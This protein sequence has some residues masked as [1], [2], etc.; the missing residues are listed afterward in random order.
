MTPT[1]AEALF[2]L[3]ATELASHHIQP[4]ASRGKQDSVQTIQSSHRLDVIYAWLTGA[5]PT[6]PNSKVTDAASPDYN[7][8]LGDVMDLGCGQGDLTGALAF[9]VAAHPEHFERTQARPTR[10]VGVD[11]APADYGSPYTLQQAQD[12][13][14]Q[15]SILK[16]HLSFVLGETA[17][18]VLQ[19]SPTQFDTVVMAHSLWYFPSTHVLKET[20][21][22]IR[23]A[24]VKRLLLAEWAMT[25]SHPDALPHLLAALLQGQSP[26]EQANVQL[27]ICPEQIKQITSDAGWKVERELTFLPAEKLQDG[28]WEVDMA[29]EA[30][31]AA[32]KLDAKGDKTVQRLQR[33]V[34]ATKFALEESHKRIG[35]RAR[36]MDVW[37]AVL[38]PA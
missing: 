30:A 35:K 12:E 37:T 27:S 14:A 7:L 34:Q 6:I 23:K 32:A 2:E 25:A 22:A 13:L 10:I 5:D 3:K 36:S 8:L 29:R 17:P 11:P 20:F 33:S 31:E 19:A 24:G 4:E 28:R 21:E 9:L 1:R 26:V 18:E 38:T 16:D 15:K